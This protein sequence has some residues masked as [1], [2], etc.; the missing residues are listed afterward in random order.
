ME[1]LVRRVILTL[2]K[3][4]VVLHHQTKKYGAKREAEN[5]VDKLERDTLKHI[6]TDG[7]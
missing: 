7:F 3:S 4:L 5:T 6:N 1:F 2:V